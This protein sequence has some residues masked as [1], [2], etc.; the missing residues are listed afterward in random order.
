MIQNVH[1][2]F[3]ASLKGKLSLRKLDEADEKTEEAFLQSA[4]ET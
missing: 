1:E 3:R 2:R 4:R